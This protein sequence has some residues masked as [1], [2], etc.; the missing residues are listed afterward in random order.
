MPIASETLRLSEDLR[1][2]IAAS[3]DGQVRRTVA[4]W[5]AA[6]DRL[7]LAFNVAVDELLSVEP[8]QWPTRAQ[9]TR[10]AR[11]QQ[12]LAAA[13]D[14][15]ERLA[16]NA[17]VDIVDTAGNAV[18]LAATAQPR[19][20]A[21]Q[22]PPTTGA[23]SVLSV[24][25]DRIDPDAINA[26]VQRVTGQIESLL[27][28]LSG[29]AVTSMQSALIRGVA[30]GDNPRT[31]ARE[32]LR[33]L[34]GEFN[35]GLTRAMVISRTEILDAMRAGAQAQQ[36][37][38]GDVLAGWVWLARL[39]RRTCPSCW[40]KHGGLH[41]LDEQGPNDHQQGRCARMPKTKTWRQLGFD[42]EEPPDELPDAQ[43]VFAQ[44]PEDDQ[45]AVM[46]S[47]RLERL[48]SGA[49]SWADLTR[50]RSTAGWRDSWAPTPLRDLAAVAEA[51]VS[52]PA[53]KRTLIIGRGRS[54]PLVRVTTRRKP[55]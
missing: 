40:A 10:A 26:I 9:I 31:A 20:I 18:D 15:L 11:P 14:E 27:R 24:S 17:G 22:L 38:N 55:A 30:L 13:A 51:R 33:R 54:S 8:G 28:P 43:A 53:T 19:I 21:S 5:V 42:L 2:T 12:A 50:K 23:T 1:V 45:L 7:E 25:F 4:A 46:G 47:G 37:A 16:R 32:M 39:D 49:V 35:G 29:E 48:R 36:E 34:E 6:W 41:R 44:L 52:R 3:V